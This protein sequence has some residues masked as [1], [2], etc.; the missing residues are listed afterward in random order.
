MIHAHH[1]DILRPGFIIPLNDNDMFTQIFND[2]ANI[3]VLEEFVADYFRY[4]LKKVRGNLILKPRLLSK[5]TLKESSKEVDLLLMYEGKKIN[6]EISTRWNQGI[7]DRNVVFLS[8][9]HGSQLNRGFKSYDEIEETVQ[10]NLNAFRCQNELKETYYLR[11]S[12][13]EILSTKFRIDIID[14][15]IGKE[16]CYTGDEQLDIL[17]KWS[18]VFMS[19]TKEELEDA[20]SHTVSKT[21]K[22]QLISNVSRLSGDDDML[23]KFAKK[24]T[25]EEETEYYYKKLREEKEKYYKEYYRKL[26]EKKQQEYK[27][28]DKKK[29][30]EYKELEEEHKKK[31]VKQEKLYKKKLEKEKEKLEKEWIQKNNELDK[32]IRNQQFATARSLIKNNIDKSIIKEITGLT[33]EEIDNL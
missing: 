17:I 21:T 25:Y 1:I 2:K 20:L 24:S 13:G 23:K 3:C 15:A 14:M 28:L 27:E 33:T 29:Q 32:K 6:I 5:N 12:K 16:M 9:I 7:K 10:I 11:N 26:D 8:N 4:D 19:E 31:L 30:Q 18:K 22:K